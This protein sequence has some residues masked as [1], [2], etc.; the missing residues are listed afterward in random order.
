MIRMAA[1]CGVGALLLALVACAA[2]M[3]SVRQHEAERNI[4]E[5]IRVVVDESSPDDVQSA[6]EYALRRIGEPA[7]DPLI[8]RLKDD[9]WFVRIRVAGLLGRI[10]DRRATEPLL[11]ALLAPGG[12]PFYMK[13]ALERLGDPAVLTKLRE[14]SG[15]P[16]L[17]D[18]VG[19]I[20]QSQR[21][22]AEPACKSEGACGAIGDTPTASCEPRSDADCRA[23]D[24]C[25]N[26]KRCFLSPGAARCVVDI[27]ADGKSRGC[28]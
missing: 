8:Q 28:K 23:A 22:R 11:D 26:E 13:T 15:V 1:K 7:V 27:C 10:G 25:A 9:D 17:A 18:T 24:V 16:G 21:C 2:S 19:T 14:A 3:S 4:P 5:L 6:A 20:E 12:R